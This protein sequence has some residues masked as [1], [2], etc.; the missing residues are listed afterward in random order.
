MNISSL[1]YIIFC[2]VHW[3]TP[4]QRDPLTVNPRS[5]ILDITLLLASICIIVLCMLY[6]LKHKRVGVEKKN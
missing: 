2:T 1:S 4:D 5:L 3:Y 6:V